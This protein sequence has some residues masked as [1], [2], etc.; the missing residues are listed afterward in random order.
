MVNHVRNT[1]T[2]TLN[3][4][5]QQNRFFNVPLRRLLYNGMIQTFFN[6]ARN[7]WYPNVHKKLKTL[8]QAAQNK[9]KRFCIKLN[10]RY[11]TKSNDFEKLVWIPIPG[12][13][14]QCITTELS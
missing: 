1:I 7:I 3:F 11:R 8:L 6:Y 10:G 2:Y 4:L 13:V 14:S 5:S 9:C 12:R